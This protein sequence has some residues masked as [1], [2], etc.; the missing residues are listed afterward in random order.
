MMNVMNV[1]MIIVDD[2]RPQIHTWPSA[3]LDYMHT[4]NIDRLMARNGSHTFTRAYCQQ[5]ICGPSRSSL[6]TGRR[7]DTTKTY[8]N[9]D[10]WRETGGNFTTVI[11]HFR[12]TGYSTW[13]VGKILHGFKDTLSYSS[14]NFYTPSSIYF[15]NF[16]QSWWN[17]SDEVL[18]IFPT[19]DMLVLNYSL[20]VLQTESA[21]LVA[22]PWFLAVGFYKP[23]LPF[24]FP[25]RLLNHY[26]EQEYITVEEGGAAKASVGLP[27]NQFFPSD[28]PG[29][30][31]GDNK[32]LKKYADIKALPF[33]ASVKS[34][35]ILWSNKTAELRRA[36]FAAV[37]ST[38]EHIG[39][40][41]QGLED[42]SFA[43]D[44]IVALFGDHGFELGD[45]AMWGKKS[46]YKVATNVPLI[47]RDPRMMTAATH[48]DSMVEL[49]DIMPTLSELAG[50]DVPP[51]CPL[52]SSKDELCT[53][54]VSF[55]QLMGG[56]DE[57]SDWK[58]FAFSQFPRSDYDIMGYSVTSKTYH[59]VEWVDFNY[60]R[61]STTWEMTSLPTQQGAELYDL[62]ND[63]DE[64]VNLADNSSF[65]SIVAAL[66][67][68]LHDGWRATLPNSSKSTTFASGAAAAGSSASSC[69]AVYNLR[70]CMIIMF[71]Y[72]FLMLLEE[73]Y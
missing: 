19:N 62:V 47:I 31:P 36:Y 29:I 53:E 2:M 45:Q 56:I 9:T 13:S 34:R 60:A 17:L 28:V 43:D 33:R 15:N 12:E 4:P 61:F 11:Q 67:E 25:D 41:L 49:V 40:L 51:L 20:D 57:P 7:P 44:T 65:V 5:A 14:D 10:K 48:V 8:K 37:S 71:I 54:G 3:S 70:V 72:Y 55:V 59:Y 68:V 39:R 52:D 32:E 16:S 42:F 24:V 64:T 30:A 22:Q 50:V 23:H 27:T 21:K 58:D 46:N 1:L 73:R 66:S 63:P 69:G 26:P 18:N 38:D 6:I 35:D